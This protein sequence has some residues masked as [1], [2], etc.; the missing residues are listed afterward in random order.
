MQS[1][2]FSTSGDVH[3]PGLHLYGSYGP[4]QAS[5]SPFVAPFA[6]NLSIT[7]KLC[8]PDTYWACNKQIRSGKAR[9]LMW[10]MHGCVK[11]MRGNV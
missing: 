10:Y 9:K 3:F 11:S 5:W 2:R 8:Q 1:N 4:K 7:Q 6:Y